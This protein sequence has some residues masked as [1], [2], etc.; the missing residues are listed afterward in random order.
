[1]QIVPVVIVMGYS[2]LPNFRDLPFLRKPIRKSTLLEAV[3][4]QLQKSNSKEKTKEESKEQVPTE[5]VKIL[6]AED[7][8]LNQKI[9]SK[10]LESLKYKNVTIVENGK[11]AVDAVKSAHY[12]IIL[13][14]MMVFTLMY[15]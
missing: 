15:C 3:R 13:M 11:Q 12:D 4:N 7:N 5:S 1:M 10:I 8:V 14:D 9:I 2:Q 6:V